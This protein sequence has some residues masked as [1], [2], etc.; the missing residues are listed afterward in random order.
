M[1]NTQ[2]RLLLIEDN[3]LDARLVRE[4]IQEAPHIELVW[5]DRLSA[6]LEQLDQGRVDVILVDLGLPDAFGLEA[7][8]RVHERASGIPVIV[9]TGRDDEGASLEALKDGAQDYLV[10]GQTDSNLLVRSMRYSIERKR[11]LTHLDEIRLRQERARESRALDGIS[12]STASMHPVAVT[13]N[14]M[15]LRECASARFNALVGEYGKLLDLAL[16]DRSSETTSDISGQI[17]DLAAQLA[18]LRAGPRDVVEVHRT[19]LTERSER[20]T[21]EESIRSYAV[22]GRFLVLELMGHLVSYYRE[23]SASRD[24]VINR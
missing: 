1:P 7:F 18:S 14:S 16:E 19:A 6:G 4:M 13:P 2:I 15:S 21:S 17:R 8:K 24:D 9:F 5:A 22:E 23:S 10:K 20:A 11:L 12:K 3:P